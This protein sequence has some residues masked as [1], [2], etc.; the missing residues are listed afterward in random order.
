MTDIGGKRERG[1][2]KYNTKMEYFEKEKSFLDEIKSI[3]QNLLRAM[4]WWK[5]RKIG[6]NFKPMLP[7]FELIED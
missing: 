6:K 5:K 7:L 1:K 2:Y 3:F 4:I